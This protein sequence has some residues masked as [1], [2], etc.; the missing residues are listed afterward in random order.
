MEDKELE[1][2]MDKLLNHP[3]QVTTQD[4]YLCHNYLKIFIKSQNRAEKLKSILDSIAED[5]EFYKW[6]YL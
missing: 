1:V 5:I 4:C 3:D 6:R 2:L